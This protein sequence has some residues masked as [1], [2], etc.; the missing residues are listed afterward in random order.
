MLALNSCEKACSVCNVMV[1]PFRLS[2]FGLNSEAQRETAYCRLTCR[3]VFAIRVPRWL[4]VESSDTCFGCKPR[5]LL[6]STLDAI[7]LA[8]ETMAF[9]ASLSA[10]GQTLDT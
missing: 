5:C 4:A 1:L 10:F 6:L 9:R 2:G 7:V 3:G 8:R